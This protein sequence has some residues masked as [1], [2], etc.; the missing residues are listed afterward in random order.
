MFPSKVSKRAKFSQ[1]Q[2]AMKQQIATTASEEAVTQE[3]VGGC[4]LLH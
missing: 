2:N 3:V 1:T 4:M